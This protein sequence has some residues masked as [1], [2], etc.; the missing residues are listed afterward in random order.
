[1]DNHPP[2]ELIIK[3][4]ELMRKQLHAKMS[5]C[6]CGLRDKMHKTN[7]QLIIIKFNK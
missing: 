3:A 4:S 7:G 1:M 2:I 5:S 6:G